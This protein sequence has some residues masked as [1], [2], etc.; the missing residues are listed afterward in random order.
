MKT[1]AFWLFCFFQA[2]ACYSLLFSA[3][4]YH[5]V[6]ESIVGYLFGMAIAVVT[7]ETDL[8]SD[9]LHDLVV[10]NFKLYCRK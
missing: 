4:I 10:S 5:S 8:F 9:A 6:I 3:S 2:H 7:F 1:V